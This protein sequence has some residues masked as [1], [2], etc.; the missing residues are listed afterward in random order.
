[1]NIRS[2]SVFCLVWALTVPCFMGCG[3]DRPPLGKVEGTVLYD[4]VP[5]KSGAIIFTVSGTRDASSIIEG[6]AIKNVMTYT[7]GDGVP[8]GEA[9]I[10]VIVVEDSPTSGAASSSEDTAMTMG[11]STRIG[12]QRFAIPEK[13]VNPE[14]SGLTATIQKGINTINLELTK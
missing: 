11:Q 12:G 1:M 8:I 14:T 4:G 9:R 3:S 7:E 10:A 6:G 13:Y 5:I 2:V